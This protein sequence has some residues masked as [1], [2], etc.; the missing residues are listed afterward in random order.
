M[1][2]RLVNK[3]RTYPIVACDTTFQIVSLSI[4]EKEKL[5]HDLM[6]I[7][8]DVGAFDRLLALIASAIVSID[9]YTDTPTQV[10]SQ[11]ENIDDLKLI[12]QAIIAHCS[13]TPTESKNSSSSS[14]QLTPVSA[15]NVEKSVVP[16]DAPVSTTQM[17]RE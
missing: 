17:K 11:L 6:N 9:G 3:Q 16:D 1:P 7:G 4:G 15:G 14:E 8:T 13:L 12:I 10:L 2:L 5:V